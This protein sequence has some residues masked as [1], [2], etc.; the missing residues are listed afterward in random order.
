MVSVN[1]SNLDSTTPVPASQLSGTHC[2]DNSPWEVSFKS[3]NATNSSGIWYFVGPGRAKELDSSWSTVTTDNEFGMKVLKFGGAGKDL[4]PYKAGNDLDMCH[5]ST[6]KFTNGHPRCDELK[7]VLTM[8]RE[9]NILKVVVTDEHV[10]DS[11]DRGNLLDYAV[12]ISASFDLASACTQCKRTGPDQIWQQVT[13][14]D[15]CPEG[16]EKECL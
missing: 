7:P 6:F 1:A 12:N 4:L 15:K 13:R 9:R 16:V 2:Q 14:V 5:N 3:E 10:V 11:H 8:P